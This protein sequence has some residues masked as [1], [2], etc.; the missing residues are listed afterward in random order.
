MFLF[1][2]LLTLLIE[3]HVFVDRAQDQNFLCNVRHVRDISSFNFV[4]GQVPQEAEPATKISV[5][6]Y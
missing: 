6:V 1:L 3:T 5:K 4:S 2:S